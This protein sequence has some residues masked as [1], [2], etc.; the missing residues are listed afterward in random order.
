L[1]T[2]E[3]T[4]SST[5][6]TGPFLTQPISLLESGCFQGAGQQRPHGHHRHLLHL[7]EVDIQARALL[8][9]VPPH[10]DFSPLF[11]QSR[12]PLDIF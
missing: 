10:D 1:G 9:P 12:D 2:L 6:G 3:R 8:A 5:L 7:I 11:G 4:H